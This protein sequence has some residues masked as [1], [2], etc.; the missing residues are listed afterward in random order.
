MKIAF[1][2][3]GA[4]LMF[5]LFI[6]ATIYMFA[7]ETWQ[8]LWVGIAF[9]IAFAV[10]MLIYIKSNRTEQIRL[11]KIKD[12]KKLKEI[13]FVYDQHKNALKDNYPEGNIGKFYIKI[14][15]FIHKK[16]SST[17]IENG[18]FIDEFKDVKE[19]LSIIK[20]FN[21]K[22]NGHTCNVLAYNSKNYG[23]IGN[24]RFPYDLTKVPAIKILP[25]AKDLIDTMGKPKLV[26]I[27]FEFEES[28]I[29]LE[30]ITLSFD[31]NNYIVPLS[32]KYNTDDL[33]D[34]V[35]KNYL[36]SLKILKIFLRKIK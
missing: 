2:I 31:E 21:I 12:K 23:L 33:D 14:K 27:G 26:N 10:A 7:Q 20:G 15:L 19:M 6:G 16:L 35:K 11:N 25:Y 18:R 29:G 9:S 34:L 17:L 32:Y 36:Q 22:V 5:I 28:P 13:N 1:R 3:Y 30:E 24:I 8:E 4:W